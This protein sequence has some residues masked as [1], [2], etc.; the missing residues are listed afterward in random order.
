MR[1]HRRPLLR[2]RVAHRPVRQQQ[3]MQQLAQDHQLNAYHHEGFW[4][5]MDTQ[6]ERKLLEDLWASGTAPWKL[7]A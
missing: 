5:P 4:Q 7:W 2:R 6:R 1:Q 3:P